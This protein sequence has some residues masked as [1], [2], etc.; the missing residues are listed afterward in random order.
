MKFFK[1]LVSKTFQLYY[2][3]LFI[4]TKIDTVFCCLG[5]RTKYGNE[6]FYKVDYTYVINSSYLCEKFNIPH[7][8]LISTVS[9]DPK[10]WF[11][12]FK[13][14]GLAEERLKVLHNQKKIETLSIFQP[15]PIVDRDNDSRFGENILKWVPFLSDIKCSALGAGL[16]NEAE[17][18]HLNY[19]LYGKKSAV[20]SNK[21]IKGLSELN[22]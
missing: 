8:S 11:Y 5:S 19:N 2:Y 4:Q 18:L 13:V 21:E 9:A 1:N 22:I 3:Y 14:K 7:F 16:V 17:R 15:G 12:Y 6:E 10:S 20:Y